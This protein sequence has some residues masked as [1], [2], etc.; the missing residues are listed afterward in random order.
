LDAKL[1]FGNR[2]DIGTRFSQSDTS[3]TY[4]AIQAQRILPTIPSH[5]IRVFSHITYWVIHS[6]ATTG[7]LE[8]RNESCRLFTAAHALKP[9]P[10]PQPFRFAQF[11]GSFLPPAVRR[12]LLRVIQCHGMA[13]TGADA[14]ISRSSAT[15][16]VAAPD[17]LF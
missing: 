14:Q 1:F 12:D 15:C 8:D 7:S 16:Q 11:D 10:T 4:T 13:T 17:G 9:D 2:L 6:L 5:P 3:T